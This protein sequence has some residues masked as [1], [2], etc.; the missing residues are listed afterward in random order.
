MGMNKGGNADAATLDRSAET[1]VSAGSDE[2]EDS[3]LSALDSTDPSNSETAQG[4]LADA[5]ENAEGEQDSSQHTNSDDEQG[6]DPGDD[7]QA[8]RDRIQERIDKLTA[9]RKA[10]EERNKE[11]EAE[12]A[13]LKGGNQSRGFDPV[14]DDPSVAQLASEAERSL[15][16]ADQARTLRRQLKNDPEKVLSLLKARGREFADESE[17]ADFLEDYEAKHRD[18]RAEKRAELA[19]QRTK[20]QTVVKQQTE[21][22]NAEA[23]RRFDWLKDDEDPRQEYIRKANATYPWLAK[24]PA[25]RAAVAFLADLVHEAQNRKPAPAS[26]PAKKPGVRPSSGGAGGPVGRPSSGDRTERRAA[27]ERRLDQNPDDD[28]AMVGLLM[29]GLS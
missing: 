5:G 10:T 15:R 25:G 24:L 20:L 8:R 19:E 27:M 13:K 16:E 3:L 23:L 28:E 7:K 12:L 4:A 6:S 29:D 11:L 17:A 9:A 14:D 18:I 21:A 1:A 22:W 2:V 26:A